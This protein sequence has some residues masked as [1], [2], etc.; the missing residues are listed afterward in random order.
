MATFIFD[1]S[2]IATA[3]SADFCGEVEQPRFPLP[4]AY[5]SYSESV[6]TLIDHCRALHYGLR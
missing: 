3:P 2:G 4:H 5:G 6:V 1:A